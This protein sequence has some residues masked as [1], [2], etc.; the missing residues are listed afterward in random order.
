MTDDKQSIKDQ[1]EKELSKWQTKMDEA[2][3][4]MHVGVKD[5]EDQIKPHVERLDQEM[6][7][8]K[9]KLEELGKSSEGAWEDLKTGVE[10]SIDIMKVA[11]ESAQEHFTKD[12][13]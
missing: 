13:K 6:T 12:K 11:F 2:K 10:G 7:Q 4:Q 3:V 1:L 8:A 9:I 5:A